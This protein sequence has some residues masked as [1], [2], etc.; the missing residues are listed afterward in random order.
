MTDRITKQHQPDGC[1]ASCNDWIYCDGAFWNLVTPDSVRVWPAACTTT[2]TCECPKCEACEPDLP[3][4]D[5]DKLAWG[6]N[7]RP[8]TPEDFEA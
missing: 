8:A 1:T 5:L 6:D 2:Y 4:I 3:E 7:V